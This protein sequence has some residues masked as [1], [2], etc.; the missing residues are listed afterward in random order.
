MTI[1]SFE[2]ICPNWAYYDTAAFALVLHP[3]SQT[4]FQASDSSFMTE[5]SRI[6]SAMAFNR[7][8]AFLGLYTIGS[9]PQ[10]FEWH[11]P[12]KPLSLN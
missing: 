7:P 6:P 11:A 9:Y 4:F 12:C 1:S 3:I 8:E 5:Q 2:I 10:P